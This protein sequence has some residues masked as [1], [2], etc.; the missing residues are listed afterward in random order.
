MFEKTLPKNAKQALAILG[1]SK[2]LKNAYLAGGT[3]LAL[4]IGHRYSYDLDWFTT[5]KFDEDK[6]I[7]KLIKLI[8][9]F[10]LERK[11]EMTILATFGG[12]K[13]SLFYSSYPLLFKT[14]EFEGMD[15]ANIKDIAAM[16]INV[17]M[18]R[19]T[20][21]D[22]VDLYCIIN[23]YKALT[24][25]EILNLYQKKYAQANP[26]MINIIQS[27]TYFV[28]A[29]DQ[30]VNMLIPL[31]WKKVKCFFIKETKKLARF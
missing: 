9:D 22:F 2:I 28:D 25:K 1:E 19:G 24:L 16:K 4:Q 21:K 11:D 15:I 17:I 18:G 10:K 23:E 26:D 31:D 12:T 29:E 27:L 13:F 30:K 7:N 5:K 20:K 6:V 8:P 3:A 14:L